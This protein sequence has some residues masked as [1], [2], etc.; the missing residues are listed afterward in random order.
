M[1]R[2]H[3]YPEFTLLRSRMRQLVGEGKFPGIATLIWRAGE[4]ISFDAV[5]CG[6]M[7][8]TPRCAGKQFFVLRP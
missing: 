6:D 2:M 8:G 3:S 5:G 1:T 4:V 7:F